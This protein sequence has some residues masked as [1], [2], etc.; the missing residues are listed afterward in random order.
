MDCTFDFRMSVHSNIIS[1]YSQQDAK[2]FDLFIFTDALRDSGGSSVY[3][4]EQKSCILLAVIWNYG[5]VFTNIHTLFR[6]KSLPSL[7]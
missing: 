5:F 4:Q 3:H 7:Y 1:N 2:F 6:V